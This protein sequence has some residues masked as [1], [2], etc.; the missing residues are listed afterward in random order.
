MGWCCWSMRWVL[1]VCVL[2]NCMYVLEDNRGLQRCFSQSH[3]MISESGWWKSVWHS[4]ST[5]GSVSVENGQTELVE[6]VHCHGLYQ[7]LSLLRH[8][9]Y[10]QTH[11]MHICMYKRI[12]THHIAAKESPGPISEWTLFFR[13][14][15]YLTSVVGRSIKAMGMSSF[16]GEMRG[17]GDRRRL[18]RVAKV[19]ARAYWVRFGS[20]P[21]VI[22]C[23]HFV[24]LM[25]LTSQ[26]P[27]LLLGQP[28]MGWEGECGNLR[29]TDGRCLMWVSERNPISKLNEKERSFS[30]QFWLLG[31]AS[32]LCVRE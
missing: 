32:S 25:L 26:S 31:W 9:A 21:I 27:T 29:K 12:D 3:C 8:I 6:C 17:G 2:C 16:Y 20:M 5:R 15:F 10:T 19:A 18:S 28:R 1:C 30:V 24:L 23:L 7:K 13:I 4:I 11:T 22:S 14:G